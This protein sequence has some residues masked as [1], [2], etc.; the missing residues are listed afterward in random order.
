[1]LDNS[2]GTAI[3]LPVASYPQ[4]VA[5]APLSGGTCSTTDTLACPG[6]YAVSSSG[7]LFFYAGQATTTPADALTG[8]SAEVGD[9]GTGIIQLS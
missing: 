5:P 9:I 4:V 3:S 2:G 8:T 7:E 1:M 6:L